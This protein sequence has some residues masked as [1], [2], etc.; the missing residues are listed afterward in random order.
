VLVLGERQDDGTPRAVTTLTRLALDGS[1]T[2][3]LALDGGVATRMAVH[4]A[5][6][7]WA[8]VMDPPPPGPVT[9]GGVPVITHPD[10]ATLSLGD[11]GGPVA[12][13]L[14]DPG[15]DLRERTCFET[16]RWF[17]PDGA[18]LFVMSENAGAQTVSR[19]TFG[20]R[21]RRAA[22]A[23]RRTGWMLDVD[24]ATGRA[25]YQ[26]RGGELFVTRWP[27]QRRKARPLRRATRP[28]A[29]LPRLNAP[30]VLAGDRLYYLR[31]DPAREAIGYYEIY[32]H[33]AGRLVASHQAQ[34][35][36]PEPRNPVFPLPDGGLL[37]VDDE[38]RDRGTLRELALDG[39]LRDLHA[40]VDRLLAL[41]DDGRFALL[42][43]RRDP[44][45]PADRGNLDELVIVDV[46]DGSTRALALPVPGAPV[47]AG[48]FVP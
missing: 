17:S 5:T 19:W 45:R 15:C 40:G 34:R 21:P 14:G 6:G 8:V 22:V 7:R 26:G 2:E 31:H 36:Y 12:H 42:T 3:V 28:V 24:E 43:R 44:A 18:Y 33:A 27:A 30:A 29:T 46:G 41:S 35:A 13:T 20:G 1:P 38:D 39:T 16:P 4:Q 11:L 47:H 25:V 32:D 10:R 9:V 48:A 23:D 37:F